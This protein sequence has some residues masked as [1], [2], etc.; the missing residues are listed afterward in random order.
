M[1]DGRT[2]I[3]PAAHVDAMMKLEASVGLQAKYE[4]DL[5]T[6]EPESQN[7]GYHLEI[8]AVF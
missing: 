5:D 8:S 1:P 2:R 4:L 6:V 3:E 7:P